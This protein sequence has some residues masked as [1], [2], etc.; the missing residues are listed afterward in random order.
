MTAKRSRKQSLPYLTLLF[1]N[2]LPTLHQCLVINAKEFNA[3]RDDFRRLNFEVY[4][5]AWAKEPLPDDPKQIWFSAYGAPGGSNRM[6]FGNAESDRLIEEIRTTLDE[7]KRNQLLKEFQ[8]MLYEAQP[9]IFL[10]IASQA[11]CVSFCCWCHISRRP[12]NCAAE[13]VPVVLIC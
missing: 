7:E 5:G 1:K 9:G 12:V 13:A 2:L 4:A 6:G 11:C 8:E 10:Q 3:L